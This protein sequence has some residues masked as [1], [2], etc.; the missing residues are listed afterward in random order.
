MTKIFK[1]DW[2]ASRPVFYND[3]IGKASYNI[4]DVIDLNNFE[5]HPEGFNS[6]LDFGYSVFEQTPIKHVKFLRYSSIL[7]VQDNGKLQIEYL[8]DPVDKWIGKTSHED[9]V[10][11]LLQKSVRDWEKSVDGEIILPTSGGYD[12]RL[13]CSM[14]ENKSRIRS[15][16][17]GLSKNQAKSLEVVYAKKVSEIHGIRWR[18]IFLGDF[19]KYFDDWDKLFGVSTHAHG[20]Y[21]FEFYTKLLSKV[22]GN[23]PFLSGIIGDGWS[24]NV[25]IPNI[26]SPNDLV[27]L[28]Y[29]HGLKADSTMSI[30]PNQSSIRERYYISNSEKLKSSLFR[31][32]ESMRLK[33]ILLSYLLSVPMYFGFNPW[34][35]FLNIEIALGMLTLPSERRKNRLWQKEFFQKHKL[36]VENMKLKVAQ[37]NVLDLQ[38]LHRISVQP[39]DKELLR[40]VVQPNY[41]NWINRNVRES[42]PLSILEKLLQ[43]RKVGGVLRRLGLKNETLRAYNAYLVL[44]PI[45]SLIRKKRSRFS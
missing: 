3:V 31:I 30:F 16:T 45:E 8:D 26:E 24:G 39:L 10:F 13:L 15:F 5:F 2:L 36:D 11:E 14:V 42:L 41:I 6:Y 23:N 32:V 22:E 12:S 19:H 21:H 35:P 40:E 25:K 34:S 37:E 17:Y 33:I 18:Q 29:T 38:G 20:M 43:I 28:G 4:N 44:K 27:H 7:T 1:T 9:D